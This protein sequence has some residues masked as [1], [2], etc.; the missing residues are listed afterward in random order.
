MIGRAICAVLQASN[1]RGGYQGIAA[2]QSISV[3]IIH[4]LI[5]AVLVGTAA[6]FIERGG[7]GVEQVMSGWGKV[8]E[9]TERTRD[10]NIARMSP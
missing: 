10:E 7:V 3:V 4:P 9:P 8:R 5:G 2:M 1:G 6:A